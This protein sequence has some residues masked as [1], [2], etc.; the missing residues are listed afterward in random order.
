VAPSHQAAARK[1]H[2]ER[3]RRQLSKLPQGGLKNR[4]GQLLRQPFL[5]GQLQPSA[6]GLLDELIDELL[7]D[8]R[9]LQR[10]FRQV[11]GGHGLGHGVSH[12]TPVP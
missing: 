8:R 4:L 7:L 11:I 3:C 1:I 12:L 2:Y 10:R 5:A 9:G 6:P